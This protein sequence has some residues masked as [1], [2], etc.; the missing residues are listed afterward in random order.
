M[1]PDN[2]DLA[3]IEILRDIVEQMEQAT[4]TI[5]YPITN[6]LDELEESITG[7]PDMERK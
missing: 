6:K 2:I 3:V 5:M 7:G 1:I 4:D